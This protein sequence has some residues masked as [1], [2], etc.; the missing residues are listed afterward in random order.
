MPGLARGRRP[1]R[2]AP[3]TPASR[4]LLAITPGSIPRSMGVHSAARRLSSSSSTS[5]VIAR[6]SIS[7]VISS[8]SRTPAMGPP[9]TAS[10]ATCPAIRPCVAP[11]KRPSV[12]KPTDSPRPAPERAA[13]TASISLIPGPPRGPSQRITT[14]SPSWISPFCT[15]SNAGSSPSNTRAGPL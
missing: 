11:E 2:G 14:T 10:G 9:A 5:T 15:A 13:V 8:P 7:S 12:N 3:R 1:R 6:F 4:S